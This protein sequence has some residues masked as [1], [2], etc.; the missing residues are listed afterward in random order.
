M[1]KI[2]NITIRLVKRVNP[3]PYLTK[4]L[5]N[6]LTYSE[7]LKP[8]FNSYNER[9]VEYAFVFEQ[10]TKLRPKTVLDVGTGQSALPSL[11]ATCGPKVTAIDNVKDYWKKGMLNHHFY[12]INDNITNS[13]IAKTFEAITCISTLEHIEK[14]DQAIKTMFSL[15]SPL[16]HIILTFPYNESAGVSNVYEL[17]ESDVKPIPSHKTRAFSRKD[18]DKWLKENN[19]KIIEQEYWQFFTGEYWTTG[20]KLDKPIKTDHDQI[21]QI[22]CLVLGKR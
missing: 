15:L 5:I 10:I 22:S 16:G 11:I 9:S 3:L 21:H 19:S 12:V 7:F 20:K 4:T 17:A 8:P 14:F 6:R 13:K 1:R 2:I 18:I